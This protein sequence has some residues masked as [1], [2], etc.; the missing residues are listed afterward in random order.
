LVPLGHFHY[1][2]PLIFMKTATIASF[3]SNREPL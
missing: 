1:P 2:F 3:D